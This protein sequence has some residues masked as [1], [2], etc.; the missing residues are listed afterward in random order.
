MAGGWLW[1]TRTSKMFPLQHAYIKFRCHN[2]TSLL[3]HKLP[4]FIEV[5]WVCF[6]LLGVNI[7]FE[8]MTMHQQKQRCLCSF[9]LLLFCCGSF[10]QS[11]YKLFLLFAKFRV[12]LFLFRLREMKIF[13]EVKTICFIRILMNFNEWGICRFSNIRHFYSI[14]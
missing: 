14:H 10:D 9:S 6:F 13:F 7:L 12:F 3:S 8:M 1:M 5:N 11:N 4:K 2:L